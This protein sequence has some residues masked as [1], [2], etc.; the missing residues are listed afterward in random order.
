MSNATSELKIQ[1]GNL[2]SNSLDILQQYRDGIENLKTYKLHPKLQ[3]DGQKHLI[4][5]YYKEE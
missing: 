5:I 4:D 3:V 1:F 2:K